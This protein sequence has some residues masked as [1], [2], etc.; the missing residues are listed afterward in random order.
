VTRE[1]WGFTAMAMPAGL[2]YTRPGGA[3]VDVL[4]GAQT[5]PRKPVFDETI[6]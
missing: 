2:H 1:D 5:L 6:D 4:P 3:V